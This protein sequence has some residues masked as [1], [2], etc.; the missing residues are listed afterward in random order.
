MKFLLWK[1]EENSSSIT[2][3]SKN[4]LQE[5]SKIVKSMWIQWHLKGRKHGLVK[6]HSHQSSK[7]LWRPLSYI[8]LTFYPLN[9]ALVID[10]GPVL[11]PEGNTEEPLH[12]LASLPVA[13]IISTLQGTIFSLP[14]LLQKCR[15]H[16]YPSIS[17][18]TSGISW[19]KT[20]RH[21]NLKLFLLN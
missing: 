16:Q 10:P 1:I 5:F 15:S 6:W 20:I 18:L 9:R 2:C 11:G 19:Q 12:W 17:F 21:F 14:L 7:T 3:P 13:A 4:P 8:L